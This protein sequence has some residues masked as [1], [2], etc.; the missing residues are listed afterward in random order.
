M[1]S[2]PVFDVVANR[3]AALLLKPSL[4]FAGYEFGRLVRMIA[5]TLDDYGTDQGPAGGLP[6]AHA[7]TKPGTDCVHHFFVESCLLAVGVEHG[8][9]AGVS[10]THV[11]DC[12]L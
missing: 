11:I 2:N 6:S 7:G 3:S 9:A 10:G 4:H 12:L 1:G 5:E 8:L